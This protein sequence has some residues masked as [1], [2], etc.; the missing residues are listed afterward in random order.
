[1]KCET[2]ELPAYKYFDYLNLK[3]KLYEVVPFEARDTIDIQQVEAEVWW[4]FWFQEGILG[5]PW[6]TELH[7]KV[8][9]CEITKRY[10]YK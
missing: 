4:R 3:R 10:L 5:M 1:M 9:I 6:G 7:P 2:K 8:D